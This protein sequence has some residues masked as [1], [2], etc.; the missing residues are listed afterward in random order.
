MPTADTDRFAAPP[1]PP[2]WALYQEAYL[3][4]QRAGISHD[5]ASNKALTLAV[6]HQR[7]E[8]PNYAR[9]G[10][11]AEMN[12][13]RCVENARCDTFSTPIR[14]MSEDGPITLGDTL[15]SGP[16]NDPERVALAR[17]L[18]RLVPDDILCLF[19]DGA[20][21]RTSRETGRLYRFRRRIKSHWDA[22]LES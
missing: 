22:V 1:A 2:D 5:T 6:R 20:G 16:E 21:P 11:R 13:Q 10:W 17:E 19:T 7:V 4:M 3:S 15:R 18:L 9:I 12:A 8:R 14:T